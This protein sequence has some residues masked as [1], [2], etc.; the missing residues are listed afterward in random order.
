MNTDL[1]WR[2]SKTKMGSLKCSKGNN[3]QRPDLWQHIMC[4][5]EERS[6]EFRKGEHVTY[7]MAY[8]SLV[9]Q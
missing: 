3:R 2:I 9:E 8:G 7:M 6:A 5:K 4:M 1:I